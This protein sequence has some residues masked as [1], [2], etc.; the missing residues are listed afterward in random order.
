MQISIDLS[1]YPLAM[2]SYKEEIWAFIERLNA[3]ENIKVVSNGMGTQVFGEYDHTLEKVM[4]EIKRVHQRTQSAIFIIK[5]IAAD[6]D[7]EY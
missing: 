2:E 7:R 4:A 5:I 1:L 3:I 6:R